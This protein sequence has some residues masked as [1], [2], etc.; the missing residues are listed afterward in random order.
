MIRVSA[1]LLSSMIL[2][3][4]FLLKL[5]VYYFSKAQRLYSFT[6]LNESFVN[7]YVWLSFFNSALMPYLIHYS[8]SV[9]RTPELLI[10]DIH[11]ILL[12]NA[13]STPICK[14]FDPFLIYR[15]V[16]QRQI[17]SKGKKNTV[18]QFEANKWFEG[19]PFD[20]AENYAYVAR[21]LLI[22]CWFASM[23]PLGLIFA[24][25]GI[26]SNYWLDKYEFFCLK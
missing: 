17:Y 22:G 4:N 16:K 20:T 2:F 3:S 10:W 26:G 15:Y 19:H 11:F 23:A 21:S 18:T 1:L 5:M 12:T 24:L 13:F 25:L 7:I 6:K 8:L 9:S 14:V